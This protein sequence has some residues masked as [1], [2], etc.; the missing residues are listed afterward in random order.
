MRGRDDLLLLGSPFPPGGQ[1]NVGGAAGSSFDWSL[2]G[3]F[4]PLRS[5]GVTADV[6]DEARPMFEWFKVGVAREM[7]IRR[8]VEKSG[9]IRYELAILAARKRG[10]GL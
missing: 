10:R 5:W 6:S 1:V 3:H 7:E 9:W 2:A 8:E 4:S